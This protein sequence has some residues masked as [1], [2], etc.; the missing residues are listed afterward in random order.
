MAKTS[1][2][3]Q[4]ELKIETKAEVVQPLKVEI[5][6]ASIANV[7]QVLGFASDGDFQIAVQFTAKA[8]PF[9]VFRLANLL[10]GPHSALYAIIGSN[11]GALDFR[12]DEKEYKIEVIRA[13][14][15]I[16]AGKPADAVKTADKA[17]TTDAGKTA[18]AV[19]KTE[20]G[21]AAAVQ[22]KKPA[23]LKGRIFVEVKSNVIQDDPNPFGLFAAYF[24]GSQEAKSA[25]GRGKTPAEAALSL[26]ANVDLIPTDRKVEPFEAIKY[27]TDDHGSDP[28][29]LALADVIKGNTF[30]PLSKVAVQAAAVPPAGQA[31]PNKRGRKAAGDNV[32]KGK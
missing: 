6:F 31:E 2:K 13:A 28:F 29:C 23:D 8:N 30:E 10:K 21:K 7:K 22:G 15:Q 18:V 14:S 5:H 9:E 25:A 4:P 26:L 17:E 3:N 27:L 16:A 32:A 20:P 11:Q 12:F 24:N 19:V 1:K